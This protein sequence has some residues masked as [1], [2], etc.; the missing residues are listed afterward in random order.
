MAR[1]AAPSWFPTSIAVGS[2]NP[3]GLT[4]V[5]GTVFF[6]ATNGTNGIQLWKSDGSAAG[7]VMVKDINTTSTGAN[8]NP[9]DLTNVDG[10]LFFRADD[11]VHGSELWKSDGTTS[12]TV[13]V[14]DINPGAA[15][16]TPDQLINGSGTLF[17]AANNGTNGVSSGKA[18]A[19][20]PAPFRT[21]LS[22]PAAAPARRT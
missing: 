19:R 7:T 2:S 13:L 14:K 18:T 3:T 12:G 6:A 5:N 22:I 4:N 21:Q 10:L 15:G 1:R 11:G 20:L 16:S 17:F 8:S 9:A